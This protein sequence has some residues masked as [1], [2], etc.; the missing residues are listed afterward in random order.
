MKNYLEFLEFKVVVGFL[1]FVVVVV[2]FCLFLLENIS[3]TVILNSK[4]ATAKLSLN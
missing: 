1:V 3:F 4:S 2:V